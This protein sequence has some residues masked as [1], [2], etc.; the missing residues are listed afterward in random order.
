MSR[1]GRLRAKVAAT[2]Y[3]HPSKNLRI[4][5]VAGPYGKTTTALLL[6]EILQ[7]SGYGV[8]VLTNKVCMVNQ[9][10][11]PDVYVPKAGALQ[12][13]LSLGRKKKVDFVIMEINQAVLDS[14]LLSTVTLEMSVLT[15]D[16]KVATAVGQQPVA[17]TV[18][19]SDLQDRGAFVV[20]HQSISFGNDD[21]ADARVKNIKLFRK[22]TE[23]ELVVDHQTTLQ[24]ATHLIGTANAYNVAAA[25]AA[26]YILAVK[27]ETLSEG[28]ARL[29][30]VPGNFEYLPTDRLYDIVVDGAMDE[31]SVQLVMADA[32]I[33][34]RRRLLVVADATISD[35]LYGSIWTKA[36][37]FIAVGAKDGP[38]IKGAS[39]ASVAVDVTLRGAKQEDMV[40]LLGMN[41]AQRDS[42]HV[43]V[44]QRLVEGSKN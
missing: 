18:V 44:G 16:S 37:N 23:I 35:T 7:E 25:V 19:P 10:V 33:L 26:A 6:S 5:A 21:L 36:S 29:E 24:L 3:R 15:G 40:V 27:I 43:S 8:L 17:Y 4:I 34:A 12:R 20:P 38:G 32:K 13:F 41:Y 42:E 39:D 2:R 30:Y 1:L 28:V 14:H 9:Q 11:L 22:G 31:R